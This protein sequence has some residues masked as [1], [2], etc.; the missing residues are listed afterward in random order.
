M[1]SSIGCGQ[2]QQGHKTNHLHRSH[3]LFYLAKD[4]TKLW[5]YR[6]VLY[7]TKTE[8][9]AAAVYQLLL[10]VEWEWTFLAALTAKTA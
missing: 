8:A 4:K 9:M 1:L 3:N 2:P 5:I 10:S 6:H 7:K